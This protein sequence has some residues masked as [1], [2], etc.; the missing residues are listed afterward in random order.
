M[1]REDTE[2]EGGALPWKGTGRGSQLPA[3]EPGHNITR[4]RFAVEVTAYP[5]HSPCISIPCL[6]P[7]YPR[8]GMSLL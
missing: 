3:P 2:A 7:V 5:P 6:S 1:G 8:P 4:S